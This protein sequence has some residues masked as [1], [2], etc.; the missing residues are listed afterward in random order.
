MDN[1]LLQVGDVFELKDGMFVDGSIA[2][3]FVY[4]NSRDL[5][6]ETI[7]EVE[8]GR[9]YSLGFFSKMPVPPGDYIV[10]KARM[11]G[12]GSGHG[13][14]DY[15]PDGW[16]ITARK[17]APDGTFDPNG[18]KVSFFQTGCFT[19]MLPKVPVLRRMRMVTTFVPVEG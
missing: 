1:T 5:L 13:V 15:Y 12:G 9:T 17:L 18:T 3:G 4:V 10:V 11:A 19:V 8:V 7:T 6:K 14:N 2:E 16:E